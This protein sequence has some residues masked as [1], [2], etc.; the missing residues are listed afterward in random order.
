MP[1]CVGGSPPRLHLKVDA[2]KRGRAGSG[3]RGDAVEPLTSA[4]AR[5]RGNRS[6]GNASSLPRGKAF[7]CRSA[8]KNLPQDTPMPRRGGSWKPKKREKDSEGAEEKVAIPVA[9]KPL[10]KSRIAQT[11]LSILLCAGALGMYT[12]P[13]AAASALFGRGL[14]QAI[15][16]LLG[17]QATLFLVLKE[18]SPR[19]T[20]SRTGYLGVCV[21]SLLLLKPAVDLGYATGAVTVWGAAF[22]AL[23]LFSLGTAIVQLKK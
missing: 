8:G 18:L 5:S 16:A 1:S 13:Q 12:L 17:F 2:R 11:I 9:K 21:C 3:R 20:S 19:W 7:V 6:D 23:V 10:T 14:V 15:G 4:G 22:I